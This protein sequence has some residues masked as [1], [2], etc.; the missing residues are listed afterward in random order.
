MSN[1][2]RY[3]T[4]TETVRRLAGQGLEVTDETVRRWAQSGKLP[5]IRLP[6]GQLRIASDDAD[7]ILQVP[8]AEPVA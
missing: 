6:S 4:V 7:A 2:P 5:A 1:Q 8:A 3:L